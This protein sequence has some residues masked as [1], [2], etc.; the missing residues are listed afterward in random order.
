MIITLWGVRG[1]IP[2]PLRP[3][4]VK[5]KVVWA[6]RDA[7]GREFADEKA[8]EDY[9]DRLPG[10]IKGTYG[11]NTPC[12]QLQS[13]DTT[14]I[15]DAG[16]GIRGLGSHLME[17]RFGKGT[18]TAHLFLSHTH[19]DHIQG[20]PFFGPAYVPGNRIFVLSPHGDVKERLKAQQ[21][22][23]YFPV[24]L[25]EMNAQIEF[26]V[27]SEGETVTV[28]GLRVSNKR[29]H[30]PGGSFGYRVEKGDSA[31]VYATDMALSD[32]DG[33][34]KETLLSFCSH[35]TVALLDAQYT[36]KEA[37]SKQ[38][39]GHSYPR[40]CI[41]LALKSQIKTLVLFHHEP[42][43]DDHT[44]Y[45]IFVGAREYLASQRQGR[46]CTLM[47]AFEGLQLFL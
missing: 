9:V 22:S 28:D 40:V 11:G 34:Y 47:M 3:E 37:A 27:L 25:E 39:W 8:I 10:H 19:W 31:F 17:D 7:A 30:H 20:F 15:F 12:V 14:L 45:E 33:S 18:G 6:L 16:S 13:G 21:T 2:A 26:V 35:A 1:S 44:L 36:I 32:L 24:S 46:A 43:C 4:E 42:A 41:D 38:A 29:L 23:S 5:A